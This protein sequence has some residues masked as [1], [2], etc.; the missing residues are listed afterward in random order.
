MDTVFMHKKRHWSLLNISL[1]YKTI[2]KTTV[3]SYIQSSSSLS[4]ISAQLDLGGCDDDAGFVHGAGFVTEGFISA[5]TCS[6][7]SESELISNAENLECIGAF[8]AV[9]T[10]CLKTGFGCSASF[11]SFASC[12]QYLGPCPLMPQYAQ[13]TDNSVGQQTLPCLLRTLWLR[14]SFSGLSLS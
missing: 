2:N 6:S 4:D 7:S 11:W 5:A 10:G 3:S 14:N 9:F 12:V 1:N 8:S 13:T